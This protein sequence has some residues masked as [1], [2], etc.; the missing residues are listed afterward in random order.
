MVAS[1]Q[2]EL[3]ARIQEYYAGVFDEQAR[4][5]TR[6]V[7]GPLEF[8]RTQEIIRAHIPSGSRVLDV[9]GGSGVHA[10]ALAD[11]GYD[12][13]LIEP[14]PSHVEQA[15]VRG[16]A[17]SIGDA[18]ELAYADDAFDAVLLLGPLYHLADEGDRRRALAEARRVVRAGGVVIAAGLSRYVAFGKAFLGRPTETAL[19]G[20]WERLVTAGVPMAGTRFPA[21]H[22][23]TSEELESEMVGSGLREVS[24]V[25][26]EGPAGLFLEGVAD[27][28]DEV[29]QA[30]LSLARA[31]E[32]ARG[33]RDFSAHLL[34]VGSV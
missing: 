12:V 34:G 26:I 30:A 5:T 27:A 19:P 33:I 23:H 11:A 14:V 32:S 16:V 18:R 7:Q 29:R 4:L 28:T 22:F 3:D 1:D 6:S 10:T 8:E 13:E 24:V 9:G 21:G 25:G 15:R 17:A 31:A 20:G 2:P